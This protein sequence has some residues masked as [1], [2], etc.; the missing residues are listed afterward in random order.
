MKYRYSGPT[1]GVTLRNGQSSTE[2]MLIAGTTVD[3]PEKHEYVQ[4]LLARGH[5][6][7]IAPAPAP[8]AASSRTSNK[9]K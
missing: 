1:S 4:V 3:L 9:D 8:A 5:L 6:T 2:V 7:P